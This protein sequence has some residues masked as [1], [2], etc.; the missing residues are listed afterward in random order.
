MASRNLIIEENKS[1]EYGVDF[2]NSYFQNQRSVYDFLTNIQ[3]LYLPA[4]ES[5]AISDDYLLKILRKKVFTIK[6]QDVHPAPEL[7]VKVG[8]LE[9]IEELKDLVQEIDLGFDVVKPPDRNFLVNVLYSLNSQHKF[10]SADSEEPKRILD[11]E[12]I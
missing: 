8:S 4:I 12:Y 2:L 10:F 11:E 3:N 7:R 5:K 6:R 9:L 1:G